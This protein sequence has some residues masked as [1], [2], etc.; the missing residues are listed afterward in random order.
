MQCDHHTNTCYVHTPPDIHCSFDIM[1]R[2]DQF[3]EA[4][5]QQACREGV[6]DAHLL[7][8]PLYKYTK[9]EQEAYEAGNYTCFQ[10]CLPQPQALVT[11]YKMYY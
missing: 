8:R 1:D 10:D 11:Q 6:R 7:S 5:Q 3:P 9:A 2:C 4:D